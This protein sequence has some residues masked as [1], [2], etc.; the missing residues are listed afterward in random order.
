MNFSEKLELQIESFIR[1]NLY[2]QGIFRY[3]VFFLVFLSAH[4]IHSLD[5]PLLSGRVID[6]TGILSNETKN[7]IEFKLK[8]HES[9]TSN[10]VVVLVIPTL[11]GENLE[12]YSL[13]VASSWKLGRKKKDN[14][15]LLLIAKEDSKLRIEVGYG[16]EDALTDAICNRIIR[17]EITPFFK[18]GEF[19][20]GV[21]RG[22]DSI[23][24]VIQG[25]Y[26]VPEEKSNEDFQESYIDFINTMDDSNI[27][28]FVRIFTGVIF[29]V[30][31]TP[32]TYFAAMAPYIGWFLYIFLMPFYGTFPLI[33]FG[34]WGAILLPAYILFMFITKIYFGFFPSGKKIFK[35]YKSNFGGSGSS[36]SF[37]GI[38]SGGGG[39][40]FGGGGGSFGGGGSS[41]SW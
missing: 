4:S 9:K 15:V 1:T 31:I 23:L 38:S 18:S 17:K 36:S 33:I 20:T 6:K 30:V 2:L 24:G 7:S 11:E 5:V 28:L 26:T 34:K 25:I 3:L 27:P 35:K 19:S 22:V 14:G 13:K 32:F 29:F 12:E 39:G 41:G 10:Q 37:S 40:S 21:E 8:E 16:L